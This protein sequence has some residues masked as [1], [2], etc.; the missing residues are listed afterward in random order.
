MVIFS[1]RTIL[2][3]PVNLAA[4]L[5]SNISAPSTPHGARGP[6]EIFADFSKI[7]LIRARTSERRKSQRATDAPAE[8][9]HS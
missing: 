7:V 8:I 6:P 4:I 2:R 9:L 3:Y 5:P 1:A